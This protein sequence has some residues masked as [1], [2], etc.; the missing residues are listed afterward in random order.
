[1][2]YVITGGA[3]FI[4]SNIAKLLVKN[5]HQVIV[6]DNLHTGSLFRL[7]DIQDKIIFHKIDIRDYKKLKNAMI[8]IDGIFHQAALTSVPESF[9]K[10]EKYFDVNVNGTKNVFLIAKELGIKVV[11]AS[12]SSVYGNVKK[13]PIT[14]DFDRNPINPYGITKVEK[15]KL[16]EKFWNHDVDIIGLRY[17]NVYGKG[18][19]GTYAGVITQFMNKLNKNLTPVIHGNGNQVRDFISVKDIASANLRAMK[20]ST[21]NGFFNIGTGKSISITELANLMIKIS[22]KKIFPEFDDD[23]PGDIEKSQAD[24]SLSFKK[25]NWKYEIELDR[26]LKQLML[27]KN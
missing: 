9:L 12:S 16:A 2:K 22:S 18:Q 20:S 24:T 1:M 21:N 8:D 3:G 14:E 25:I 17:F 15:E 13:I 26:G 23:L 5:G 11:F 19:T 4:G 27:E 6:I 10:P 7:K